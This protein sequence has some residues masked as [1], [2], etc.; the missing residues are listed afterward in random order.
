MSSEN[1]KK[2]LSVIGIILLCVLLSSLFLVF[3]KKD[4]KLMVDSVF[5]NDALSVWW[6]SPTNKREVLYAVCAIGK[7][8]PQILINH[9]SPYI[10]VKGRKIWIP[11]D[12]FLYILKSDGTLFKT[13]VL[14]KE[15]LK[16][17]RDSSWL[18]TIDLTGKNMTWK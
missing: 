15:L 5:Y 12:E 11:K 6:V 17:K 7:N 13:K 4:E 16:A 2:S 3:G 10:T 8:R 9:Q 18:K 1:Y 14:S